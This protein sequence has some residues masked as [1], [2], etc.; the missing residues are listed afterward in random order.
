MYLVLILCI[1]QRFSQGL[2]GAFCLGEL[3]SQQLIAGL[4]AA[5]LTLLGSKSR[6]HNRERG[7][8]G[9]NIRNVKQEKL[10]SVISHHQ[11]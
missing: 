11:F 3:F 8:K 10:L 5:N 9:F 6:D 4:Q 1:L 2:I 7:K